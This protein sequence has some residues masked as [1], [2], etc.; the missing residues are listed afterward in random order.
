MWEDSTCVYMTKTHV[1]FGDDYND[2]DNIY[3]PINDV[4]ELLEEW[5]DFIS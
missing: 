4:K 3:V 5:I 1:Q 2:P